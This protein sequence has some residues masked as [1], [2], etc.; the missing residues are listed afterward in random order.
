[1]VA[2][3]PYELAAGRA[4]GI[5]V[6]GLRSG[7]WDDRALSG[8]TAIYES[9]ADLLD[10]YDTSPLGL[11]M[12]PMIRARRQPERFTFLSTIRPHLKPH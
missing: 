10:F 4:A 1:M 7:G 2:D 3:T 12:K 11:V 5:P 6:I 9:P 8:A